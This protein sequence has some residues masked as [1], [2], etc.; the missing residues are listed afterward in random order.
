MKKIVKLGAVAACFV[1]ASVF[2]SCS[3]PTGSGGDDSGIDVKTASDYYTNL[4]GTDI[5]KSCPDLVVY[6]AS[7][8]A[9]TISSTSLKSSAS[10]RSA[11]AASNDLGWH[12]LKKDI[13]TFY[14]QD[15]VLAIGSY[16][17]G[18]WIRK[19]EDNSSDYSD[20]AVATGDDS[21]WESTATIWKMAAGGDF[22]NDGIDEV[23]IAYYDS[24]SKTCKYRVYENDAVSSLQNIDITMPD[25][26]IY[27]CYR[28]YMYAG[29]IDG[30]GK[31]EV[32]LYAR[33][34][35]DTESELY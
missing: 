9:T 14:P 23:F 24:S 33:R 26:Y 32:V 29:D 25:N 16:I 10:V 19:F 3:Q 27:Y 4:I 28:K 31:D 2:I 34:S 21:A 35:S 1:A 13:T 12:P 11:R 20:S 17:G 6:D 18:A 8:N 7:G 22:D 30:D 5:T 15:E